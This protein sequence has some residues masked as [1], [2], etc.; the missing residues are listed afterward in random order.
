MGRLAQL[1]TWSIYSGVKEDYPTLVCFG[2][3]PFVL[4]LEQSDR[5]VV[6]N[7]SVMKKS[8]HF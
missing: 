1:A 3:Y 6:S 8:I 4:I 2:K 5:V 7:F